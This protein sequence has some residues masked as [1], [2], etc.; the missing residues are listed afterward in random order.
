MQNAPPSQRREC[1]CIYVVLY[2]E[3]GTSFLI[4]RMLVWDSASPTPGIGEREVLTRAW[5]QAVL[6]FPEEL[7]HLDAASKLSLT[8]LREQTTQ[9]QVLVF[10]SNA[11]VPSKARPHIPRI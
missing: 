4:S 11:D 2:Q 8:A 6:Y 10:V 9:L 5:S 7:K 3:H 1:C